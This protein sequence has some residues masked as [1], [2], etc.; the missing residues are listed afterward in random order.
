MS[1]TRISTF[2]LHYFRNNA[3]IYERWSGLG[4]LFNTGKEVHKATG[5]LRSRSRVSRD[6]KMVPPQAAGRRTYLT[7][8]RAESAIVGL[9]SRWKEQ[10]SPG[11]L[12]PGALPLGPVPSQH[13]SV[14]NVPPLPLDLVENFYPWISSGRIFSWI[15]WVEERA[16]LGHH[17]ILLTSTPRLLVKYSDSDGYKVAGEGKTFYSLGLEV[18]RQGNKIYSIVKQTLSLWVFGLNKILYMQHTDRILNAEYWK[19]SAQDQCSKLTQR[20]K[21]TAHGP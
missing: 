10:L 18:S 13:L 17:C 9:P 2:C 5:N 14:M 11:A 12:T 4:S 1:A 21:I 16:W 20:W 8:E 7:E 3:E 19:L 6:S 15:I